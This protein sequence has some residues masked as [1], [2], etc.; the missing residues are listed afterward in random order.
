MH[1]PDSNSRVA[2][3]LKE[4]VRAGEINLTAIVNTHQWVVTCLAL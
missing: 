4:K 1:V 3:V 2:P